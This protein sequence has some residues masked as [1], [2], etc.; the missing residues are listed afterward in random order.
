MTIYSNLNREFKAV[1]KESLGF[2]SPNWEAFRQM[3]RVLR[4]VER[5]KLP[6]NLATWASHDDD[7]SARHMLADI[8]RSLRTEEVV[9]GTT[10]CAVGWCANDPWFSRRGLRMLNTALG[11]AVIGDRYGRVGFVITEFFQI[12]TTLEMQLFYPRQ[13]RR[14][15]K[16]NVKAVIERVEY[17]LGV[18]DQSFE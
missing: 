16:H 5:A 12:S 11:E 1:V 8:R 14:S 13:Y 2:R 17:L 15:D 6:F 3:L 9:C 7:V 4:T 18:G 10:A